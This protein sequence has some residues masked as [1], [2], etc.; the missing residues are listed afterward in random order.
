MIKWIR[1][2]LKK[3]IDVNHVRG[4]IEEGGVGWVALVVGVDISI[5]DV[6]CMRM[7]GFGCWMI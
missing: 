5:V 4:A 6:M 3:H 1:E 2:G 7:S